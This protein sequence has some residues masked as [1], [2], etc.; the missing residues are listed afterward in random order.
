MYKLA[1]TK[2]G[3]DAATANLRLGASLAMAGD[4]AG[5]AT[6]LQMVTTG[7]RAQ[8]AQFWLIKVNGK[9]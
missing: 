4:K 2:G 5:A 1:G 6:A 8:L 9:A 7:P 3:V